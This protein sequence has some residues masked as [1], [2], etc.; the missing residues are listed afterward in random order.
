MNLVTTIISTGLLGGVMMSQSLLAQ[1]VTD[2]EPVVRELRIAE[3]VF[4]SAMSN[5][6]P[7]RLRVTNVQAQFLARQGVLVSMD[8]FIPWINVDEFTRRS[9]NI[10]NEV[11]SLHDIPEL[12][13]EI[14]SELNMLTSPMDSREYEY[15]RELRSE[16]RSLRNEQREVRAALRT[17]RRELR[18]LDDTD[19]AEDAREEL[20]AEI[21]DLEQ[22]LNELDDAYVALDMEIDQE[23]ERLK[24][25]RS[26]YA[27]RSLS[28]A[29]LDEAV[30]ETACNYG[31]TFKSL[32]TQQFLTVALV[33]SDLTKY[34]VFKMDQIS[35][36][37][38]GD[39]NPEKLL[40]MSFL[41]DV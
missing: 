5:S 31:G 25:I 24:D 34:Y 10:G 40:E 20:N 19:P 36:C 11:E 41:Y 37:Q 8:V 27:N 6:V 1:P 26:N 14:F 2:L 13:H 9:I 17:M 39:I 21:A 35:A 7:D 29:N 4:R 23:H 12:I 16:Q 33:M 18:R 30:G 32:D 28:S 15:L 38:R 22:S 3:G